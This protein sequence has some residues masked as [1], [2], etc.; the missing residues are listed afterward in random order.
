MVRTLDLTAWAGRW[1][2]VD[3]D[4]NVCRDAAS[5]AELLAILESD[6]IEGTEIMRAPAPGEP[7]V[8]GLG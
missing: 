8:Y 5:L 4:G 1:V 6:G 2:A 7:V 3:V